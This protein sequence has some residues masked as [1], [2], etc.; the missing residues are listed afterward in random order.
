MI[1]GKH[2]PFLKAAALLAAL[3]WGAVFFEARQHALVLLW[4]VMEIPLAYYAAWLLLDKTTIAVFPSYV[5]VAR[6]YFLIDI[7]GKFFQR[8]S[9]SGLRKTDGG[10]KIM[11]DYMHGPEVLA[12]GL[13]EEE[14]AYI[15]KFMIFSLSSPDLK[16]TKKKT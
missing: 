8:D 9:I 14:A 16:K 12:E 15:M 13:T 5:L 3:G 11:F 1:K 6:N 7:S 10:R 2:S 4:G